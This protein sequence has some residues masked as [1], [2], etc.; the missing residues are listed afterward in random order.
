MIAGDGAVAFEKPG[1]AL[2]D[3][4]DLSKMDANTALAGQQHL[5]FATGPGAGKV[6][7]VDGPGGDTLIQANVDSDAAV[8]FEVAIADGSVGHGAYNAADFIL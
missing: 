6:W 7:A 4:F 8:E 5:V 3:R 2:G 1:A